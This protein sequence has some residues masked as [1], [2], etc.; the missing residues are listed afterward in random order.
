MPSPLESIAPDAH[1]ITF[2]VTDGDVLR[3]PDN[4]KP[5]APSAREVNWHRTMTMEEKYA[6]RWRNLIGQGI[7][8]LMNKPENEK[9][10]LQS[11]PE[12]YW[13]FDHNK[14]PI[15][16]IRHDLYL[17]G[18][19]TAQRFRSP[20]EFIPHGYW[21]LTDSTLN[22]KNCGCKYCGGGGT[23]S[24]TEISEALGLPT[25]RGPT[26]VTGSTRMRIG[27]Q[28]PAKHHRSRGT[29][30][31][32]P[33]SLWVARES[34]QKQKTDPMWRW[35]SL[36]LE[37]SVDN[38]RISDLRSSRR[39]RVGE[40]VWCPWE[41]VSRTKSQGKPV[42]LFW[43]AIIIDSSLEPEI[44]HGNSTHSS[45][46][47]HHRR[48]YSVL[49]F[50][51]SS[52]E[53]RISFE[54]ILEEDD[55]MPWHA[56]QIDT[57]SCSSCHDSHVQSQEECIAFRLAL[58]TA[59]RLLDVWA[60][61]NRLPITVPVPSVPESHSH[62]GPNDAISQRNDTNHK[63]STSSQSG[64]AED[65]CTPYSTL[66]PFNLSAQRSPARL[67]LP[68]S[69]KNKKN[70]IR[71]SSAQPPALS[72]IFD[73]KIPGSS[74]PT[75]DT[76]RLQYQGRIVTEVRYEGLWYGAERIWMG[77]VIRLCPELD[78]FVATLNGDPFSE[79]KGVTASPGAEMRCV[80]MR[81]HKIFARTSQTGSKECA[82]AGPLYEVALTSY[83]DPGDAETNESRI[84]T[85]QLPVA[86]PPILPWDMLHPQVPP[87]SDAKAK[88]D[89]REA[90][91]YGPLV[92]PP[93]YSLR[94]LLPLASEVS[95][96]ASF[97]AGRYYPD[98]LQWSFF[99][100]NQSPTQ[101]DLSQF[102]LPVATEIREVQL[103]SLCGLAPGRFNHAVCVDVGLANRTR[104]LQDADR[105]ARGELETEE[106]G[107]SAMMIDDGHD[108]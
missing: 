82:I 36:R 33:D 87:P 59:R 6:C 90:H 52:E 8:K 23:K 11:F 27:V 66:Y 14:G 5:P 68:G 63:F 83:T 42:P 41:Q 98:I 91:S 94:P 71:F 97:I 99:T 96:P 46:T 105:L 78:A 1:F 17:Y 31:V 103:L 69:V 56:Y 45:F 25:N 86:D 65:R 18:S 21:L 84:G 92:A 10:C 16:N 58:R 19:K 67:V 60:V 48:L 64:I 107:D 74:N 72:S 47:V 54:C 80:L 35:T 102:S 44:H 3:R 24:Q 51:A 28:R 53:M 88:G 75:P 49:R 77:D 55:I 73:S 37:L 100:K 50:G 32:D 79:S 29:G 43:P 101:H 12:G 89:T 39:F 85:S 4:M 22:S 95:L 2:P 61:C 76:P 81:I 70:P 9:H 104:M 57:F 62:I 20:A 13:M 40:L 106:H 7:A 108:L 26:A 34:R 93:G 15:S 30:I 38:T